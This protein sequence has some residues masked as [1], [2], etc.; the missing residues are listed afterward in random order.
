MVNIEDLRNTLSKELVGR[1]KH[2]VATVDGALN[3]STVIS[4]WDPGA[5]EGIG[6]ADGFWNDSWLLILTGDMKDQRR[7][8]TGWVQATGTLTVDPRFINPKVSMLTADSPMGDTTIEVA[9]ASAFSTGEA[10]IWDT[11]TPGGEAVTI[12]DVDTVANVLT[13]AAPGIV[14]PLGYLVANLAAISM[15]PRITEGTH[16]RLEA[17]SKTEDTGEHSNTRR[18]EKEYGFTSLPIPVAA[19]PA[20]A[21][22]WAVGVACLRNPSGVAADGRTA[23]RISTIYTLEIRNPDAAAQ[24]AWL[25]NDTPAVISVVYELAP[26][27]TVII[28]YKAG[29]T[30]GDLD[31]YINGSIAG[32]ECTIVGTEE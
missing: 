8:V 19:G 16:F 15:S 30:T 14:Q 26:N 7:R 25:E 1:A 28:D 20:Q 4:L 9:D 3:G 29:K 22:V 24:T 5:G 18:Y 10:F 6:E 12:T 2:G 17:V 23:G 13:I 32:I 27:D 21:A 31:L 11:V